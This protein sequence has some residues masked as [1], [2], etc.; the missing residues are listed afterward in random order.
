MPAPSDS[1]KRQ[2][3]CIH[4]STQPYTGFSSAFLAIHIIFNLVAGII[5]MAYIPS[6]IKKKNI[7]SATSSLFWSSAI[8]GAPFVLIF[9][10]V[11]LSLVIIVYNSIDGLQRTIY[12]HASITF[13]LLLFLL[14]V[15]MIVVIFRAKHIVLA[16][17]ECMGY[18][19]SV[20][21]CCFFCCCCRPSSRSHSRVART[22]SLWFV[23]AWFQSIATSCS[24]H[25]HG[26]H[27]SSPD[28]STSCNGGL[29]LLWHGGFPCCPGL[30]VPST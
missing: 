21:C 27:K 3:S 24:C 6:Q 26:A 5:L 30:H 16:V 11:K 8:V 28:T 14:T 9:T 15:E 23:M 4:C 29:Y 10:A 19:C 12:A 18:C 13:L 25:H 22:L 1:D 20:C 17:P 7:S 2:V